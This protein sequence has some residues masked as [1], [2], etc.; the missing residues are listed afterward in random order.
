MVLLEER[1]YGRTA[2]RM[3]LTQSAVTRR[4]HRLE[5]QLGAEL[6]VR[7]GSG[8]SGPT[9]AG[10]R[11][12][13]EARALLQQAS[14]ARQA[15]GHAPAGHTVRLG[16]PGAIGDYPTT[17]Q[18]RGVADA[19]RGEF[20]GARLHVIAVPLRELDNCLYD[21]QVDVLW[22]A[23]LQ[24]RNDSLSYTNLTTVRRVGLVGG[25]HELADTATIDGP[26]FAEYP[27]FCDVSAPAAWMSLWLLHDMRPPGETRLVK[28]DRF[29]TVSDLYAQVGLGRTVTVVHAPIVDRLAP[30]LHVLQLT[31]VLDI[32][33]VAVRRRTDHRE[34]VTSLVRALRVLASAI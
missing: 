17:A 4:L 12:A 7:G 5:R 13:T 18:L 31:G 32:Q 27:M 11:F 10:L 21:Q 6:I 16:V 2:A 22:T 29:S 33:Y 26:A 15:A 34:V 3:H 19:L 24:H 14:I 28:V 25:R 30:S 8:V 23:A 1:H 20:P 9:S